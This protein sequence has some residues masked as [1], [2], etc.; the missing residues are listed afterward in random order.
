MRNL[1][2]VSSASAS[3]Q[4]ARV[5]ATALDLDDNIIYIASER[6]DLDANVFVDIKK[7]DANDFSETEV[8]SLA[9]IEAIISTPHVPQVVSLHVIPETRQLCLILLNGDLITI[10]LGEENPETTNEG[11]VE[12]G[13]LAATWSPDDSLLVLLTGELKLILMTS[14]FEV[15]SE[16]PLHTSDF[17]EDAPINVGWGSKQT[18]FHGSLG[19]AAAQAAPTLK[20]GLSPD[21]DDVPRISWRGDGAYFVVS[22]VSPQPQNGHRRRILRVYDRQ[23]ALQSTME[24]IAGLEHSLSWRPSG[25]LIAGTQRFGFDG[26]GSGRQG[27]HDIVFFERNGLRH[28]EFSLR[29]ERLNPKPLPDSHGFGY[30]VRELAW[31]SDSNILSVWIES[32][33]GDFV[34]LWTIGNY[35]WYFKQEI[36]APSSS[37]SIGRFTSMSWHPE[38][39]LCLILTTD[40]EVIQRTYTWDVFRSYSAPPNDSGSVAVMDGSDVLLTP[41][42]TQNVPPPMCSHKLEL[43]TL[44]SNSSRVPIH[45]SYSTGDSLAILWEDGALELWALRTRLGPGF[46]DPINPEQRYVGNIREGSVTRVRQVSIHE[47]DERVTVFVLGSDSEGRDVLVSF[48]VRDKRADGVNTL[49]LPGRNGCLVRSDLLVVW[50]SSDGEL[51]QVDLVN[52]LVQPIARF[53]EFCF[54]AQ[55][56]SSQ[57]T[58]DPEAEPASLF[59][60]HA[61]SGK[62]YASNDTSETSILLATNATSFTVASGFIIF[63]TSAHEA[64]FV[65]IHALQKLFADDEV[66]DPKTLQSQWE[67]R[68]VERGS[69][70]VVAVPSVMALV[71]Q[72][73]RGNLE[74]INPRPL[75]L[76]VVRQ[77]MHAGDYRKAFMA[78]R[79]HRIDFN[80]LV[81]DDKVNFLRNVSSFTEQVHEV[82]HINLFLTSLSQGSLPKETVAEL[83][84]TVRIVLEKRDINKY[85]NSILTAYVVKSPPDHE[86]ALA[87]LPRLRDQDAQ[88]V[89]E[90][91]KY[92]IFLVDAETLFNIALGM[93]DFSLVLMIAQHAQKDPREYLPFLRELRTFEKYYQRFKI[94]DHL[95]RH[96]KALQNL[97]LAGDEHFDEAMRYVELHQLF[98]PAL[99]IWKGTDRYNTVLSIYGDSL[100]ERREFRQAAAAFIEADALS[101]ALVAF[102]RSLDWQELFELAMRINTSTENISAMGYRVAED[103]SSKKRYADAGRVLLDY[104]KD[105]REA[106]IA[107]VQGNHFA[108]ARRI[109]TMHAV[110]ELVADIIHPGALESRAQI[111]EEIN[112]MQEQLRKQL[113]RIRELRVKKVEEPDAFYGVEDSAL[114]NVDVMTDVSMP[115]TAFTRYTVA[116]STASRTSKRSSRSKRKMARKVGS[117]RKGTVDEEEYLLKSVTKLVA[118]FQAAQQEARL[119]LPFLFQ[120]TP[121]HRA[122][123]TSLQADLSSLQAELQAALD[124]IWATKPSS[125]SEESENMDT[126]AARMQ[127]AEKARAVE[128]VSK[129]AKPEVGSCGWRLKMLDLYDEMAPGGV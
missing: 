23:A 2:L 112:E 30:K 32:S 6:Q 99:S 64:L 126:W 62:L 15:L 120:F 13:I 40:T 65:P 20:V 110:P 55:H 8:S 58:T 59:V 35:H 93:Y 49:P 51:I 53:P 39:S 91:V 38:Q 124:D 69:K 7:L 54:T 83:C 29:L 127:E 129:I 84:D 3:F 95:K 48:D 16:A 70:I 74:T 24:A 72:M 104:C 81:E 22:A 68:R 44:R 36:V 128:P 80:V 1:S 61:D 27:R 71:L 100:F 101:K 82:D 78:C 107:F 116:P 73:P 31:S 86:A 37:T 94:D 76:E 45:I 87:L 119:L 50:Q 9:R 96:A 34:Q 79:K 111:G 33:Q 122:E 103:L 10:P 123:G 113:N 118:R 28:G 75:V 41:F 77:D 12:P 66:K 85:V 108:E 26:A 115:A 46:G 60:G 109:T 63:T 97:R 11:S 56:F 4:D 52:A 92:I 102:E 88:L 89:E 21:D 17:G 57:P 19:K 90:A 125:E 121:E 105:V 106:V 67:R 42:R 18:Q 14:T 98:E 117:G 5:S 25:N 47:S 114:A 43:A